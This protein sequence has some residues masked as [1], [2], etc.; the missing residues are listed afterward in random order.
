MAASDMVT[1]LE[2]ALAK[3]AG[4]VQITV[5]GRTV[6]YDRAQAIK[7]LEFWQRQAAKAAGTR[8]ISVRA[9]LGGAW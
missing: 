9:N 8:P 1:L 2:A 5:D 6:R 7:E 4:V 3:G